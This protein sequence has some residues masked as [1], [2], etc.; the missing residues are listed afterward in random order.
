M[1]LKVKAIELR[2]VPIW[3]RM[4]FRFGITTLTH[5]DYLVAFV[6]FEFDGK[7]VRGVAAD[8][9]A[10][11]WFTKDPAASIADEYADMLC[12]ICSACKLAL[13]T[14][15]Q[16]TAFEFWLD[17]YKQVMRC[18]ELTTIPPLLKSFGISLLERAA[19]DTVCRFRELPFHEAVSSNFLGIKLGEIHNE[20]DGFEPR[21]LLPKEPASRIAIRHTVGLV[22]PIRESDIPANERLRDGLPQSLEACLKHYGIRFLKIKIPS[23]LD[24]A[25]ERLRCIAELLEHTSPECQFTLDGNECFQSVAEFKDF[26]DEIHCDSHLKRFLADGLCVIEQ[27][28]HRDVALSNET[29]AAFGAWHSLPTIIID[30]SDAQ[31][32]SL[33][34]ALEVGY[35]GTSHKNCK[36]V[37]KGIANA[38]LIR[39]LNHRNSDQRYISTG[40]D[41]MN[42]GPVALLQDL[43]VGATLGFE[44]ME[45]NGHHFVAGLSPFPNAIQDQVLSNHGDLYCL[46]SSPEGQFPTL[47]IAN[48]LID[49]TSVN[50]APFGYAIELD[51]NLFEHVATFESDK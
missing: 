23:S 45:R 43:A 10:P 50:R 27:P 22:D 38:C 25:I 37:F 12:V 49:L 13:T 9:L 20:L 24:A 44:H 28:L 8:I 19:I 42:L 31:I 4:P 51:K 32:T 33:R 18:D 6:D 16:P 36:G 7:H 21:D 11:K 34:R 30:E 5:V 15:T 47:A 46:H 35:V 41:L 39:H 3:T 17:L 40:E 2:K 29:Q 1:G 26:W 14:P 48:G